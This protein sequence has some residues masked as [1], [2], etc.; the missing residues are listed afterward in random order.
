MWETFYLEIIKAI[1]DFFEQ[2]KN[3]LEKKKTLIEQTHC[4]FYYGSYPYVLD[5]R[6]W[7]IPYWKLLTFVNLCLLLLG[8]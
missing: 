3:N 8:F 1:S 2:K 6:R 4:H 7:I 5:E